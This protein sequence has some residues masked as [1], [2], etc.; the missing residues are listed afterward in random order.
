MLPEEYSLGMKRLLPILLLVFSVGVGA[1]DE[2]DLTKLK[3]TNQCLKCDLSQARLTGAYLRGVKLAGANLTEAD[4]TG[5]NFY[6]VNLTNADLT[7][8][9]LYKAHMELSLIHI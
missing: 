8:A 4:L 3:T 1:Y 5:A 7:R 2:D 9:N 6:R